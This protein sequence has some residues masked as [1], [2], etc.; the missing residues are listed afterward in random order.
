MIYAV[1]LRAIF[2]KKDN[3]NN[4]NKLSIH[5]FD[6]S[7]NWISDTSSELKNLDLFINNV[8]KFLNLSDMKFTQ[9]YSSVNV[10]VQSLDAGDR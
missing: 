4:S 7:N 10:F 2:L 1:N 8:S 3:N 9:S 6:L 5:Y